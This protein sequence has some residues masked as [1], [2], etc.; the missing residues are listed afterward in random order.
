M[1]GW[2]IYHCTKPIRTQY[3]SINWNTVWKKI[4]LSS[5]NPNHQMIHYNFVHR[6]YCTPRKLFLMQRNSSP[7]CQLC[8]LGT[9]GT[10]IHMV[11][12][13]PG[14]KSFWSMVSDR[15]S[16]ALGCTIPCVPTLLLLNDLTDL[17]LS[18]IHQRWLLVGLTAAKKLIAQ[19]WKAPHDLSYQHWVNTTIDIAKLERSVAK[20]HGAQAKNVNLW[21]SF[22][23]NMSE[24]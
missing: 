18:L 22:I 11:W 6:L 4:V 5:R 9:T 21:T 7:N 10:F 14:V 19:R 16:R 13:C 15:L 3:S 2:L 12:D 8:S 1:E 17:D 20:I 23:E 24:D